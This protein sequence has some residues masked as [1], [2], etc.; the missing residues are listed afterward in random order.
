[1][2]E[3]YH[4]LA[5]LHGRAL[6]S[7]FLG[8]VDGRSKAGFVG[9][10]LLLNLA[11]GSAPISLL[12][13]AGS[14]AV[15]LASG[16]G[17][18]QLARRLVVPWYFA[19]LALATQAILGDGTAIATA[20]PLVVHREGVEQGALIAARILG[21]TSLVLTLALTTSVTDLLATAAWLRVPHSLTEIATLMYRYVFLFWDEAGRIRDAQAVRLGYSTWR[22]SMGSF[23]TLFGLLLLR[24]YER[25][26][27]VHEAMVLRGYSGRFPVTEF[28]RFG[29]ADWV[30]AAILG[31]ALIA[32]WAAG[33][34][35]L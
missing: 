5:L 20:G 14:V 1:M 22:K 19:A 30:Q 32:V 35:A 29:A 27:S 8:K 34:A 3:S 28:R 18:R 23:G 10:G 24:S 25:G 33:R 7:R 21:G 17:P 6:G 31:C 9:A 13:C 15:L 26:H 2:G 12:L 11:A 16:L 4:G